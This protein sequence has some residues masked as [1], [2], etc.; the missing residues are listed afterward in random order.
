MDLSREI[1]EQILMRLI[2]PPSKLYTRGVE[3]PFGMLVLAPGERAEYRVVT[4][5]SCS[6]TS[7]TSRGIGSAS[8]GSWWRSATTRGRACSP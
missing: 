4:Q 2:S 3:P 6:R 5:D 1:H 7:P 8:T